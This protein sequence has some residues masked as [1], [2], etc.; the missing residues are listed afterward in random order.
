MPLVFLSFL[1]DGYELPK[2]LMWRWGILL[3]F[4]IETISLARNNPKRERKKEV[5]F[6]LPAFIFPW[7]A[8]FFFSL[9]SLD[10]TV[11]LQLG[12]VNISTLVL[13][14]SLCFLISTRWE[15]FEIKH[16]ILFLIFSA[17]PIAVY[18]IFQA[19]GRDFISLPGPFR[20]AIAT[21]GHRNPAAEYELMIIPL[22]MYGAFFYTTPTTPLPPGRRN[23]KIRLV[24]GFSLSGLPFVYTHFIMT[25][26]RGSYFALIIAL[27]FVL[28]FTTALPRQKT[29]RW[30]A[31]TAALLLLLTGLFFARNYNL[32]EEKIIGGKNA[33]IQQPFQNDTTEIPSS[34]RSRILIWQATL[35]AFRK[36]PVVGVGTGNLGEVLPLYHSEELK[37]RFHGQIEA[38][39]SHNEYLQILAETGIPGGVSFLIFLALLLFFA[40]RISWRTAQEKNEFLPFFLT[41]SILGILTAALLSSPLQKP[42]TLFLFWLFIGFLMVFGKEETRFFILSRKT[43][44]RTMVGFIV[45]L[46]VSAY[47]FAWLPIQADFYGQKSFAAFEAGNR[48]QAVLYIEKALSFQPQNRNLLTMAGNTYLGVGRF[49][50]AVRYYN[51]VI[52]Y[53]PYWPPGYGNMGLAL[54]QAGVFTDAEKYLKYSLRLDDYQPLVRNTLG[55]IYF[56]EGKKSEAKEEFLK[57][58]ALDPTLD[59]PKLNLRELEK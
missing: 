8:F 9:L 35:A 50:E 41:A 17:L 47:G 55:T 25:H 1:H 39:N 20:G 3:I 54:A 27:F 56:Q 46:G 16:L 24:R 15:D 30:F 32:P 42:A 10:G 14:F 49:E 31:G 22:L 44:E 45:V 18:G 40:V 12:L 23:Q 13:G 53:H 36:H 26:T 51:R 5:K 6:F 29:R 34:L 58:L 43:R 37:R 38:G 7:F 19:F 48:K 4:L 2:W 33:T 57:A 11:N 28:G 21:F 59:L 52:V